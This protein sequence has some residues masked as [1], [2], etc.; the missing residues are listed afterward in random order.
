MIRITKKER[1]YKDPENEEAVVISTAMK[2]RGLYEVPVALL[3]LYGGYKVIDYIF[4]KDKKK[5]KE[6]TE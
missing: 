6:E 2:V 1:Y 5:K 4:N 3:I